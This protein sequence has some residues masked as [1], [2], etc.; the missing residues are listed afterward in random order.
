MPA[1]PAPLQQ[2]A[3]APHP[4]PRLHAVPAPERRRA[5]R[6]DDVRHYAVG[7]LIGFLLAAAATTPGGILATLPLAGAGLSA[8]AIG[9]ATIRMRATARRT[10]APRVVPAQHS[11]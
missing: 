3:P 7:L 11:R 9:L 10:S 8:I 2:P 1:S 6:I 4:R 5:P